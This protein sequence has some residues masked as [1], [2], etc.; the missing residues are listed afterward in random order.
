VDDASDG[1]FLC[2]D[3]IRQRLPILA[4]KKN[5]AKQ[6]FFNTQMLIFFKYRGANL[7]LFSLFKFCSTR[8]EFGTS[9]IALLEAMH[10]FLELSRGVFHK[11]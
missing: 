9:E 10:G 5:Q 11:H 6:R 3:G 1:S 7:G 2:Y 8:C 4:R